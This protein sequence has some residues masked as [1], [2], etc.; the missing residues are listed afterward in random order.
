MTE[1][2]TG[3]PEIPHEE[4]TPQ[5][6]DAEGA[7]APDRLH[8]HVDVPAGTRLDLTVTRLPDDDQPRT[9]HTL[10]FTPSEIPQQVHIHEG[11]V[12]LHSASM[13]QRVRAWFVRPYKRLQESFGKSSLSIASV[14]FVL[15]LVIYIATR[16]Y[17]LPDYP[18][19]FFTDEAI[20]TVLAADFLRDGLRDYGG[21]LLP[22]YFK[23]AALYNLSLSVYLQLL[24]TWL[25][26]KSVFI[27][28]AVSALVT[29]LGA[30]AVS[31]ILRDGFKL[32]SWWSGVLVL[33]IAPAWFLHSRTAFETVLMVSF[34]AWCIYFYIRYRQGSP[35]FL[36]AC[37]AA[38]ALSFYSYSGGQLIL[39][40]TAAVLI[41]VDLRYHWQ[42]R[43]MLLQALILAIIL[44]LPYIRF[45]LMHPGETTFHLR[46][47]NAY[48]LED[49]PL[50]E[51]LRT[52]A[53]NYL[54]SLD[55]SY[56]FFTNQDDLARHRMD[57]YGHILWPLLPFAALGVLRG[58]RRFREPAFRDLLLM[59]VLTPL[60]ASMVGVGITRTMSFLIPASIWI[61]IGLD[62]ALHIIKRKQQRQAAV[63]ALFLALTGTSVWL[64]ASALNRGST[65]ED[66]YG[67]GGMQYGAL[68]V[69]PAAEEALDTGDYDL[70]YV[71]PTWANG[72][73]IIKRFFLPDELPI[74]M[75]NAQ[76]F[77]DHYREELNP[78]LLFILTANEYAELAGSDKVTD[79]RV[80]QVIEYPDGS[81]G[82]FFV[83][84]RYADGVEA[85]FAA[86]QVE[87]EM[88]V[89][90]SV[91]LDNVSFSF[92]H[93]RLDMGDV[94]HIF[95][96]D[97]FTMARIEWGNPAS[98]TL[99]FDQP[100][101][102]SGL[103]LTTGSMDFELTVTI[104]LPDG[105]QQQ[106]SEIFLD[107]PDDPT[108]SIAFGDA[109][110]TMTQMTFDIFN[111]VGGERFQIHIREIQLDP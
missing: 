63:L 16:L 88:P 27:T 26:G 82:F 75:G 19:Y 5:P 110:L 34:Y 86:E 15:A 109:P 25:F 71:T 78:R 76:S 57:G 92:T 107:L 108:V 65:W 38:G 91:T 55:P 69:F 8:I 48:W 46:T 36:L 99:A 33:G 37:V 103:T 3:P 79:L 28:R 9:V 105:S 7:S 104:T 2:P 106:F 73:D 17:R 81:P 40:A 6:Q 30:A 29:A 47:L 32:R 64:S 54:R 95:D 21:T 83:S 62:M 96:D 85:V 66:D 53:L 101:A 72:A 50:V 60:G 13:A 68:Q 102:F 52:F 4:E 12:E 70:I 80:D 77:L 24:P 49:L 100:Q 44:A 1:E 42:H 39:L 93:P 23:N 56:W 10:E 14:L 22:A 98:F 74:F 58:F 61:A 94:E 43:S 59:T 31:L 20:H 87:R 45:Q 90:E 89:T 97:T 84:M 111:S 18:I 11:G 35:H 67:L 41:L 51:K